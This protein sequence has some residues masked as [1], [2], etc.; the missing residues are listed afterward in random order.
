VII[1]STWSQHLLAGVRV[2]QWIQSFHGLGPDHKII[3]F[4]LVGTCRLFAKPHA[5]T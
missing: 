5:V 1:A 3:Q 4:T 2:G